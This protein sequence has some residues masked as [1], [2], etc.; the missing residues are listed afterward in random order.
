LNYSTS[1]YRQAKYDVDIKRAFK[2]FIVQ[3]LQ[4]KLSADERKKREEEQKAAIK[5]QR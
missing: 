2:G 5:I 4:R 3:N 1:I